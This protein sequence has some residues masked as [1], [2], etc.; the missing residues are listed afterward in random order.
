MYKIRA[1]Y[2]KSIVQNPSNYFKAG[3]IDISNVDSVKNGKTREIISYELFNDFNHNLDLNY[4]RQAKGLKHFRD[5]E[6]IGHPDILGIDYI[7]DIKNSKLNDQ[8]LIEEYKY[9]LV[10]Y[11]YLFDIKKVYLFVDN[12]I[13]LDTD[14][15]KCRLIEVDIST[16]DL[17]K[18]LLGLEKA[19]KELENKPIQR[20]GLEPLFRTYDNVKE[21]IT[22]LLNEKKDLEKKIEIIFKENNSVFAGNYELKPAFKRDIKYT[23][24]RINEPWNGEY[25][26]SWELDKIERGK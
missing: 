5:F 9:Q 6:I 13:D 18:T 3:T 4:K 20:E 1:S 17:E 15:N 10:T 24:N 7:V 16:I 23:M 22:L 21:Q 14:L 2:L 8:Q 26:R 19:L 12:N 25:K 11:S